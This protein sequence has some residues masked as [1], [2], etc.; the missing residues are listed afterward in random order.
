MKAA[1]VGKTYTGKY[2]DKECKV[3]N[4]KSEGKYEAQPVAEGTPFTGKNKAVTIM[5]AGK[6]VTCKKGTETGEYVA[7]K[8]ADGGIHVLELLFRQKRSLSRARRPAQG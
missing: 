6:T 1:K 5:A 2:S 3:T 8:V 7:E 4:V